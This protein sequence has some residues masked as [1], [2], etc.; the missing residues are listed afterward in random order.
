MHVCMYH[1]KTLPTC[2]RSPMIHGNQVQKAYHQLYDAGKKVTNAENRLSRAEKS[3]V[4]GKEEEARE[5]QALGL[6]V[7][8]ET[9]SKRLSNR[10]K[11]QL[12]SSLE[13]L[14]TA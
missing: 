9:S 12:L 14:E 1:G 10:P 11:G 4:V 2:L 6:Q 7:L 13:S 3:S 8:V 5:V